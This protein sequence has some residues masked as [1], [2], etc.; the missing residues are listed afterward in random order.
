MDEEDYIHS[1]YM[2]MLDEGLDEH[3]GESADYAAELLQAEAEAFY[4]RD[5]AGQSGHKGFG[6]G[7]RQFQVHGHLTMEERKARVQAL[8][9]RTQ[10]RKCGQQGH[11]AND[12]QCPRC[13]KSNKGKGKSS[14]GSPSSASTTTSSPKSGKGKG[15]KSSDT[16]RTVYFTINE[17][18]DDE[19]EDPQAYMV[20]KTT[21]REE[22][23]D[24]ML[25]RLIAEA[26]VRQL[27]SVPMAL[28]TPEASPFAFP[29]GH[30]IGEDFSILQSDAQRAHLDNF[31]TLV[32]DPADPEWRDAYEERWNEFY[33]GH[34]YF[35][36]Q[37]LGRLKRWRWKA[38]Q[39]LP[40][41]PVPMSSS[42]PMAS[43]SQP[44]IPEIAE[45]CKCKNLTKQG[46]NMHVKITR[47]KDCGKHLE[48]EKLGKPM[49]SA[50][51]AAKAKGSCDHRSRLARQHG[52]YM[53][54]E[55]QDM[56]SS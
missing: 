22:T 14:G 5:R 18:Q 51:D 49:R 37:D 23:T 34:P 39:G 9:S 47:C 25:D 48:Y 41:L 36:E 53:A 55:V 16:P 4:I 19:A 3:D 44:N 28:T 1:V 17:Y 43:S 20:L 7:S 54:V 27:H 11:W 45:I 46:S 56:W 30:S 50:E 26:Q 15:G 52:N 29:A 6:S 13:F 8:K 33:P 12:P 21:G 40:R 10:C 24:E 35:H 31:M 42:G 32:N 2:N 38:E